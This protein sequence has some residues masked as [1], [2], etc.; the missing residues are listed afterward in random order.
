MSTISVSA[1]HD[2]AGTRLLA[3]GLF[4]V[5]LCLGYVWLMSGLSKVAAGHFPDNLARVLT[6][7]TQGQSGWY[8]SF[9]DGVVIP[10][11]PTFGY[12][13]MLGELAV[14]IVLILTA[15][16]Y[17][18]RSAQLGSRERTLLFAL[19]GFASLAGASMSLNYQLT[20]G[21]NPPWII[22]PDP[23]APGVGVDS[24]FVILQ[25]ILAAVC[26]RSLVLVR[27]GAE[28]VE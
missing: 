28:P 9:V 1:P 21:A 23:Y 11:G 24:I 15:L 4:A 16:L 5:Q 6:G 27:R 10:N 18:V 2:A 22:S 13:T 26:V 14:G 7:M 25:L 8:K 17:L 3:S 19:V 20:T 12:L